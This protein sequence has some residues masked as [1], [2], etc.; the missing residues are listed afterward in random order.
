MD[1]PA[2]NVT[3]GD[4][5]PAHLRH[6]GQSGQ[7]LL[8]NLTGTAGV[9]HGLNGAETRAIAACGGIDRTVLGAE[10]HRTNLSGQGRYGEANP[11]WMPGCVT[12][13]LQG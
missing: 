13:L 7:G 9:L 11:W 4:H 8:R 12:G 3:A 6:I 10:H 2:Q 1:V 5:R